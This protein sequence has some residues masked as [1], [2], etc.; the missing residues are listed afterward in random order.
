[1]F[2]LREFE[3]AKTNANWST[4]VAAICFALALGVGVPDLLAQ[5]VYQAIVDKTITAVELYKGPGISNNARGSHV[6]IGGGFTQVSGKQRTSFACLEPNGQLFDG[7]MVNLDGYVFSMI[8]YPDG[9]FLIGGEFARVNNEERFSIA[10]LDGAGRVDPRFNPNPNPTAAFFALVP[11]AD[12]KILVGG[13]FDSIGGQPRN[14]IARLNADGSLDTAFDPNANGEIRKIALQPDGKIV[15]GGVFTEIGGQTRGNIARLN[16]DGKLDMSFNPNADAGVFSM[17]LQT[18]GKILVGGGFTSVGG[19][20]RSRMARLNANGSIDAAFNPNANESVF[21]IAIQT[22]GKIVA[23]GAFTE[24]GGQD[25]KRIARLN[26]DGT[27]DAFKVDLSGQVYGVLVQPDGKILAVGDF[28]NAGYLPPEY[29]T[30]IER[31]F[32]VRLNPDGTL[33]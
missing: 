11:Q 2:I 12:G 30:P 1:M 18:D 9:R 13:R 24:I 33:D 15:L 21:S 8:S 6:L 17:A 22:D 29:T 23:G 5:D 32:I 14:N 25:R 20:A 26:A 28:R 10:I 27:V 4:V 7:V 3:N 19:Q 31:P 16:A